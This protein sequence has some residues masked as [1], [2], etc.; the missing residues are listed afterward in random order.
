M[1]AYD[2]KRTLLKPHRVVKNEVWAGVAVQLSGKCKAH[3][4]TSLQ[5]RDLLI[6]ER[7]D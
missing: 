4:A 6:G 3:A 5:V 7:F 1:S 2:P